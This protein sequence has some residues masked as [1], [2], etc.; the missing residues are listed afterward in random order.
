MNGGSGP[1][2]QPLGG[3]DVSIDESENR[4]TD[5]EEGKTYEDSCK[6]DNVD[7]GRARSDRRRWRSPRR[8]DGDCEAVCAA[9]SKHAVYVGGGGGAVQPGQPTPEPRG[10]GRAPPGAVWAPGL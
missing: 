5:R 3:F 6:E 10:S 8:G 7:H 4:R 1:W 2:P 9:A